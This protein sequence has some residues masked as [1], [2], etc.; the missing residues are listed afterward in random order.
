M[1]LPSLPSVMLE[2][3]ESG[4]ILGGS[5]YLACAFYFPACSPCSGD[6]CLAGTLCSSDSFEAEGPCETCSPAVPGE[7]C[8]LMCLS[9]A[10][11]KLRYSAGW[12]ICSIY[13]WCFTV[14]DCR[15]C[16]LQNSRYKS[17]SMLSSISLLSSSSFTW[18][19]VC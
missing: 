9:C 17:W 7:R 14:S 5:R 19:I 15:S 4:S 1:S 8:S 3:L 2:V 11:G 12:R 13:C 16:F 10:T 6:S 18:A